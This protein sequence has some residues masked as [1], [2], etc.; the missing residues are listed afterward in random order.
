MPNYRVNCANHVENILAVQNAIQT[1]TPVQFTSGLKDC[2]PWV[3]LR[4]FFNKKLEEQKGIQQRLVE[5]ER[6]KTQL[7]PIQAT[8]KTTQGKLTSSESQVSELDRKVKKI[9][10][11]LLQANKR[12]TEFQTQ[13]TQLKDRFDELQRALLEKDKSIGALQV[14]NDTLTGNSGLMISEVEMTR[15]GLQ[16]A[17]AEKEKRNGLHEKEMQEL[18]GFIENLQHAVDSQKK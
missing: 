13:Y 3:D 9:T 14:T 7:A 6:V 11:D 4:D 10:E 1:N 2:K 5:G 15:R 16:K 17:K 12:A 18:Q 8:L